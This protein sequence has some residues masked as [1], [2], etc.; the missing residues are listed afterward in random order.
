M[1]INQRRTFPPPQGGW[2]F[3]LAFIVVLLLLLPPCWAADLTA[4]RGFYDSG[5]WQHA[6]AELAPL[7]EQGDAEAQFLVGAMLLDGS[8]ELRV[9]RAGALQWLARAGEQGHPKAQYEL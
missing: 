8:P 1:T 2:G 4:G 5:D 9:D 3:A 6:M 7:A